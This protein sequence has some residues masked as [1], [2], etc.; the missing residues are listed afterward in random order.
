MNGPMFGNLIGGGS[1][2]GG[3]GSGSRE[4]GDAQTGDAQTMAAV[5]NVRLFTTYSIGTT[6]LR[7]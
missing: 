3:L 7:G 2:S 1:G 6:S 5:K 4:T